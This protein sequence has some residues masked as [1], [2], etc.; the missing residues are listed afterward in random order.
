MEHVYINFRATANL[1]R[2]LDAL[3]EA[4][5]RRTGLNIK[6]SA[7]IRRALERDL[8]QTEHAIAQDAAAAQAMAVHP[9]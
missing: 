8:Q 1:V 9:V 4:E 3:A 5:S 2:R 7:L 6:R